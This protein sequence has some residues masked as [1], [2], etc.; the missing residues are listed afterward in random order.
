[1]KRRDIK[2]LYSAKFITEEQ[3]EAIVQHYNAGEKTPVAAPSRAFIVILSTLAALL[4]I[5]GALVLVDFHWHEITSPMKVTAGIVIMLLAWVGCWLLAK[6][7]PGVSE[8]LGL[9]GAGMW[10]V[11][12]VIHGVLFQPNTPAVVAFFVFFIGLLPIPFLVRQRRLIGGV[13]LCSFVLLA[14]MLNDPASTWLSLRHLESGVAMLLVSG[15][16]LLWWMLAER[17]RRC[18]NFYEDYRWLGPIF[19]LAYLAI[20]QAPLMYNIGG[21]PVGPLW[22]IIPGVELAA[23]IALLTPWRGKEQKS[24]MVL[25]LGAVG[26]QAVAVALSACRPTCHAVAG[27]LACSAYALLLTI[28][29][30]K[31]GRKAWINYSGVMMCFVF[32][33]LL[34]HIGTSLSDSGLI[35][36]ATGIAVLAF[37]FLLEGQRRRLIKKVTT[38]S[39][40]TTRSSDQ[41]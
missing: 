7:K 11:N 39:T 2:D 35:I 10:G 1:M 3:Y 38:D 36:M 21:L 17:F 9:L 34:Y 15:L 32:I 4:I 27:L 26:L 13:A 31:S 19:F 18:E 29:G 6:K 16:I 22:W 30:V 41:A 23:G 25:L 20:I 40:P 8:G 5:I 24:L 28:L 33:N 37:A 12:L 14:L